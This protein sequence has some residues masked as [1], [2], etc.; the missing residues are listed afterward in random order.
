MRK[1]II[2]E[3]DRFDKLTI[4]KELNQHIYPSGKSRRR[5]LCKCDCGNETIVLINELNGNTKSCGCWRKEIGF[6]LGTSEKARNYGK[7]NKY[8]KHGL[9]KHKLYTTW[10]GLKQ[11]CY[12][13]N[14]QRYKDY[15][16]RGIKVCDRWINS[17][18]NFLDDM[19]ER[20]KGKS[21][22]RIDVNGNYE[23]SNCRWASPIEQ[24]HNKRKKIL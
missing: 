17:F 9:C 24:S 2:K 20:P 7:N 1:I 19:G 8:F 18:Q 10:K 16:G 15:G 5:F 12:N 11:R 3:G 6:L 22:D 13:P 21:I 14:S 23:P 4:I